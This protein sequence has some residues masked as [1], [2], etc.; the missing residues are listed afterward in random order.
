M[1]VCQPKLI[2]LLVYSSA[3]LLCR[4]QWDDLPAEQRPER[5]LLALRASLNAFANLRP[6][7]VL[8]QL[9]DASSL[10]REIV[11]GTDIMIV[12]E[13]VGGI[14]FGQPRVRIV[15]HHVLSQRDWQ[16]DAA[17]FSACAFA[18]YSCAELVAGLQNKRERRE[19]WIQ[20]NDLL[21]VRGDIDFT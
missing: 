19:S 21:R 9:A 1:S 2:T 18:N 15:E 5:G 11:E 4:Y 13:L 3:S 14:Y 20:H 6:A 7:I 8:P 12:R 17:L 10:K 16:T